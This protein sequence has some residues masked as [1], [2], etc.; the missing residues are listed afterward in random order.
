MILRI[1]VGKSISQ[2]Y[3]YIYI[4]MQLAVL[5]NILPHSSQKFS[6]LHLWNYHL[7]GWAIAL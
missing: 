2:E 1:T 5:M 7:K 4:Y 6:W 3:I